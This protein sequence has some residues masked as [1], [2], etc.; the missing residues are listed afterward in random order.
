MPA[1]PAPIPR[2][3]WDGLGMPPVSIFAQIHLQLP[4]QVS[5]FYAA[6]WRKEL[7]HFCVFFVKT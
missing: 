2:L 5:G 6:E 3:S 1:A 4:A 7:R